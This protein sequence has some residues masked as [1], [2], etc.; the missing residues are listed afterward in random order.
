[1]IARQVREQLLDEQ[2]DDER[3]EQGVAHL[4]AGQ[5]LGVERHV[6]RVVHLIIDAGQL[7]RQV[8]A[9]RQPSRLRRGRVDGEIAVLEWPSAA[10]LHFVDAAC[11][12]VFEFRGEPTVRGRGIDR[13]LRA[14]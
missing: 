3:T 4:E 13:D 6:G 10:E 5:L 12:D 9:R 11:G 2:H 8:G 1:M 7:P 14:R